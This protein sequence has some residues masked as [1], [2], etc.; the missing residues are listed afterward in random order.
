MLKESFQKTI[1]KE[2]DFSG[3]GLHSG[4][5]SYVKLKPA[6]V[7]SGIVFLRKDYSLTYFFFLSKAQPAGPLTAIKINPPAKPKFF[8][9]E[10]VCI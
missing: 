3:I 1:A 9:K 4:V 7:D 6:K 8:R 2:I 5:E 10:T